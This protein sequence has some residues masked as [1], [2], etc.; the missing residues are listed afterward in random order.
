MD[1]ETILSFI[2]TQVTNGKVTKDEVMKTLDTKVTTHVIGDNGLSR[3]F[4]NTTY[5]IGMIIISIAIGLLIADHWQEM[6]TLGHII[7]TIGISAFAF[8][9]GTALRGESNRII[10]E[11]L[12]LL[13]AILA[14]IGIFVVLREQGYELLQNQHIIV[15][16]LGIVFALPQCVNRRNALTLIVAAFLTWAYYAGLIQLYGFNIEDNWVKWATIVCGF[17]Y[18]LVAYTLKEN[19]H[20]TGSLRERIWTL[21]IIFGIGVAAIVIGGALYLPMLRNTLVY[22]NPFFWPV[23]CFM[24]GVII[25][26]IGHSLW[27]LQRKG[28]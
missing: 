6:N 19:S 13:S 11:A 2:T 1:K 23:I 20:S 17:M 14:P 5:T 8:L 28:V 9:S 24:V 16:L 18:I 10:S 12:F 25:I 3:V 7:L 15:A 26:A 27:S 21:S 22:Y 4:T